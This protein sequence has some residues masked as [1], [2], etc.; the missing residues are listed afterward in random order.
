[1]E[2]LLEKCDILLSSGDMIFTF[3]KAQDL[4]VGSSLVEEDKLDR[5][6]TL[7]AKAKGVSLSNIC[8]RELSKG[9]AKIALL[10]ICRHKTKGGLGLKDLD[11]RNK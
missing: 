1:M 2:S 10:N 9:K 3:Y 11:V 8:M 6:T 7:L 4:S 5:A